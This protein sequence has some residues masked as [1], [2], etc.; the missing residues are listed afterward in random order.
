VARVEGSRIVALRNRLLHNFICRCG[1]ETA[2][3]GKVKSD[4]VGQKG[5]AQ[6]DELRLAVKKSFLK[7]QNRQ[8]VHS[9]GHIF[10][11]RDAHRLGLILD[12]PLLNPEALRQECLVRKRDLYLIEGPE[13]DTADAGL[14]VSR[15]IP[16][17]EM[18]RSPFPARCL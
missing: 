14:P 2:T 16:E 10:E 5:V 1:V 8:H 13:S 17:V 7:L 18:H 9:A 3:H 11:P 6:L 4:P 12:P 15:L